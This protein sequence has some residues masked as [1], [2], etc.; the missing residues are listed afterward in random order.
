[1]F[2]DKN[3]SLM[4]LNFSTFSGCLAIFQLIGSLVCSEQVV[5]LDVRE[6]GYSKVVSDVFWKEQ[7]SGISAMKTWEKTRPGPLVPHAYKLTKFRSGKPRNLA[8]FDPTPIAEAIPLYVIPLQRTI[9]VVGLST[10]AVGGGFLI[11]R[12]Q[13]QMMKKAMEKK[14]NEAS[15]YCWYS[16]LIVLRWIIFKA[17]SIQRLR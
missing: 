14:Q 2:A 16:N 3:D 1:M 13:D 7:L 11:G 5:W 12:W 10:L 8:M 6:F 4:I 15:H 17:A 9:Q